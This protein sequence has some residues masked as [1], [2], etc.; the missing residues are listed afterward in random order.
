M[1][2]GRKKKSYKKGKKKYNY[3]KLPKTGFNLRLPRL[4]LRSG[5]WTNAKGELKYF[6]IAS[7]AYSVD[8][9]GTV[10]VLNAMQ[11]GT[12]AVTRVGKQ[13]YNKSIHIQGY[14]KPYD[15]TTTAQLTRTMLVWDSQPNGVIATIANILTAATPISALNLDNRE[16]FTILRDSQIALAA[17][18]ATTS[19]GQTVFPVNMF[20]NLGNKKTTYSGISSGIGNVATGALLLVTIG[21]NANGSNDEATLTVTTRL[22]YY[23]N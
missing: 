5:G 18:A 6:D 9:T 15:T 10:T 4:P 16:R 11:T 7:T 21:S 12:D 2:K 17:T 8:T 13:I 19:Q 23:D 1:A 3:V 14:L 22:R 20:V